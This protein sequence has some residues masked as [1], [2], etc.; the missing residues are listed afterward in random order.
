MGARNPIRCSLKKQFNDDS[1]TRSTQ[2]LAAV[3]FLQAGKDVASLAT[4]CTASHVQTFRATA[5]PLAHAGMNAATS[6]L[7]YVFS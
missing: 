3:S 2:L 5:A 1:V 4:G 6:V 7:G